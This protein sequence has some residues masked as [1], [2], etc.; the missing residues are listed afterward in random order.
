[1]FQPDA[2]DWPLRSSSAFSRSKPK[3]I[4]FRRKSAT[5]NHLMLAAALLGHL[6]IAALSAIPVPGATCSH[7]THGAGKSC[8]GFEHRT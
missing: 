3:S 1:M 4:I 6:I 7:S 8:I 2:V 5:R